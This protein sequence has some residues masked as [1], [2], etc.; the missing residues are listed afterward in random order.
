MLWLVPSYV[1]IRLNVNKF[2]DF[3][4]VQRK[5]SSQFLP[6]PGL[7]DIQDRPPAKKQHF[8]LKEAEL[9]QPLDGATAKSTKYATTYAVTVFKGE[10]QFL[11]CEY[12]S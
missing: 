7:Q 4:N 6:W 1:C 9:D 3:E 10:K 12:N 2:F 5:W 8:E 11:L